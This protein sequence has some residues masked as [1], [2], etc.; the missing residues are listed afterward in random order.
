MKRRAG[1]PAPRGR[2]CGTMAASPGSPRG[3]GRNGMIPNDGGRGL[4]R[5]RSGESVPVRAVA[6]GRWSGSPSVRP[7]FVIVDRPDTGRAGARIQHAPGGVRPGQRRRW[8]SWSPSAKIRVVLYLNQVE[9]NFRMLRFA[10]PV[11]IQIGHGESDK[12]CSVSNQHKAY[13]LTFVGGEAGRDRLRTRI[14]RLRRR[15]ANRQ[16]GRPQL[17]HDYPGAPD[18]PRDS[19]LRVWYA[20]T[21]EG[22]RPEHRVRVAGQPRRGDD[23]GTAGGPLDPGHLSTAPAHRPDLTGIMR[24]RTEGVRALLAEAATGTWSTRASTAGSGGSPTPAS[25]TS[26]RWPTTG[27]RPA[28]RW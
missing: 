15:P 20:P 17:D 9:P 7:V 1:W 16:I 3:C 21:W 2:G 12:G 19:G 11:H 25:P 13:D 5:D 24:R 23:R 6:H 26:P 8:R 14:A 27:W 28:S 4:L 22:D 18:W 10:E